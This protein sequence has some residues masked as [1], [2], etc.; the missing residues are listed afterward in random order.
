MTFKLS[1]KSN[2]SWFVTV[3]LYPAETNGEHQLYDNWLK[4][5][6]DDSGLALNLNDDSDDDD[7]NLDDGEEDEDEGVSG[8]IS[9]LDKWLFGDCND[10]S[11]CG[12]FVNMIE[13]NEWRWM[14][15]KNTR[16]CV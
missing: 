9:L 14:K 16:I 15:R 3:W 6:D 1:G 2:K 7:D 13:R 12:S 11:Y 4:I 5:D 8:R 10:W